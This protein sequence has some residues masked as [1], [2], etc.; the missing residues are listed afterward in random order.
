MKQIILALIALLLS[1]GGLVACPAVVVNHSRAVYSP[2]VEVVSPVYP[3]VAT[4]AVTV[5]VDLA[6]YSAF[7]APAVQVPYV[8]PPL[9]APVVIPQTPTVAV[10]AMPACPAP[11]A[12]SQDQCSQILAKL[13]RLDSRLNAVE[14]TFRLQTPDGKPLPP[15]PE[16]TAPP[17]KASNLAATCASCHG[18]KPYTDAA[19]KLAPIFFDA[20]NVPRMTDTQIRKAIRQVKTQKMPPPD[21]AAAKAATPDTLNAC[22]DELDEL[23]AVEGRTP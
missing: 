21:S 9:P 19:G 4:T 15:K 23:T 8:A 16:A 2:A 10:P 12:L 6:Q 14:Q 17:A 1:V 3:A 11:P 7:L 22:L 13:D 18:A 5:R 20:N